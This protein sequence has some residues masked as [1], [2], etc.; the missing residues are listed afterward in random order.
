MMLIRLIF[1][2]LISLL[3]AACGGTKSTKA[4]QASSENDSSVQLEVAYTQAKQLLAKQN[5]QA[6]LPLMEN[7]AR[8]ENATAEQ[9]ANFGIV[10]SRSGEYEDA[11]SALRKAAKLAPNNADV[12]VE[13]AL[14][15]REQGKFDTARRFY[16]QALG[17]APNHLRANYNLGILC[18]LYKED[19]DCAINSYKQYL[20]LLGQE[21]KNITIWLTDLAKRKGIT[22]EQALVER[23]AVPQ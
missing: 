15:Y 11:L 3:L 19:L 5:Y 4:D 13:M 7:V 10:L 8:S 21:D 9:F 23:G 12:L 17:V 2:T 6:A 16:E 22:P 18:D 14:V 1:I 20:A